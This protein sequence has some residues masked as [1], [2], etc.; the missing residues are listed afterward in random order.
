MSFVP[1]QH[2]FGEVIQCIPGISTIEKANGSKNTYISGHPIIA[3]NMVTFH[4]SY[5][6]VYQLNQEK[7]PFSL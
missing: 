6:T 4:I 3:A 5:K 7:N 2:C 1:F